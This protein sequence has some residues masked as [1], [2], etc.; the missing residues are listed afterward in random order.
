M[1]IKKIISKILCTLFVK[2]IK[3]IYCENELNDDY[4]YSICEKCYKSLTFNNQK[5]CKIC[6]IKLFGEYNVCKHCYSNKNYF[7]RAY[8]VFTYTGMVRD[9]IRKFKFC[10]CKYMGE[11]LSKFLV[12]KYK[13]LKLN[14]DIVLPVPMYEKKK[15]ERGYNQSWELCKGFE[16]ILPIRDDILIKIKNTK[17]QAMS[18]FEERKTNLIDCFDVKNKDIIQNKNVLLID[19]IFTTGSTVNECSKILRKNGAK[20]V[21]VLTLSSTEFNTIQKIGYE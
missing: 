12:D 17:N 4:P 11:Y 19:D 3:C 10:D 8:S 15:Q 18:S 14:C 1:N 21:F 16:D 2:D 13:D 7:N 20:T 5:I 6:G 9:I